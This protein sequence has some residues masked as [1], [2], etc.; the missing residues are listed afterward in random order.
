MPVSG[1][2]GAFLILLLSGVGC[3]GLRTPPGPGL[4]GF[5]VPGET[6]LLPRPPKRLTLFSAHG[7]LLVE[8][9]SRPEIRPVFLVGAR[10]E[11]EARRAAASCTLLRADDGKGGEGLELVPSPGTPIERIGIDYHV[12]L[13][14][15]CDLDLTTLSGTIDTGTYEAGE[16]TAVTRDG[17]L[18]IGPVRKRLRFA[19]GDG[20][21]LLSGGIREATG[22]MRA[23]RVEA[24]LGPGRSE[25][26]LVTDSGGL[27]LRL[28]EGAPI[29]LSYTTIQ[30]VLRSDL[31]LRR[32][33]GNSEPPARLPAG[34]RTRTFRAGPD[35]PPGEEAVRIRFTSR[36]GN[37]RLLVD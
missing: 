35:S 27:V 1:I 3:P 24:R 8:G 17:L 13:P 30:G 18:R 11:A 22:R 28:P 34:W 9:G 23:G 37:L 5:A 20:K 6:I 32:V 31:P 33:P 4:E 10:D 14:K 25:L 19:G 2:R 15:G 16:V 29:L 7:D 12:R 36:E 21:V 26:T